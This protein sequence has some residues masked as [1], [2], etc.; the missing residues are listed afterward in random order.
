MPQRHSIPSGNCG[1]RWQLRLARPRSRTT[2]ERREAVPNTGTGRTC[3][4]VTCGLLVGTSG[5][6][7]TE[8]ADLR[9]NY[10]GPLGRRDKHLRNKVFSSGHGTSRAAGSGEV[11]TRRGGAVVEAAAEAILNN[12]AHI[13]LLIYPRELEE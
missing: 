10:L 3:E 5:T 2:R 4:V 7:A 9:S 6:S 11:K 12:L 8:Q 1:T 13:S